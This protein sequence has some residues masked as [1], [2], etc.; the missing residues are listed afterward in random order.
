MA[1]QTETLTTSNVRFVETSGEDIASALTKCHNKKII[2]CKLLSRTN[3]HG[4][5]TSRATLL[6]KFENKQLYQPGDHVGVFAENR[7]EIVSKI[8]ERLK[9][10]ND[11]DTP[12]ELQVLKEKHTPNGIEKTWV[13][14]EKLPAVSV[15]EMFSRF[16][17]ITTPPSPNLLQH[18]A[19]IATDEEDQKR[20]NLLATVSNPQL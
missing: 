12:V 18:F 15:R 3:L 2:P 7:P 8:I 14:H 5:D 13:A 10:V 17:D 4:N 1:L 9:G 19:S 11:P 16:L 20:L 6:L